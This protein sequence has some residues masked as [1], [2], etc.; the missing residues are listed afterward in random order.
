[1]EKI[2]SESTPGDGQRA[3]DLDTVTGRESGRSPVPLEPQ[4]FAQAKDGRRPGRPAWRVEQQ[5]HVERRGPA[6]CLVL[7]VGGERSFDSDDRVCK[8]PEWRAE[9]PSLVEAC[10]TRPEEPEREAKPAE[11]DEPATNSMPIPPD[12]GDERDQAD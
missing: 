5:T 12:G 2:G 11:A 7:R 1:M 8:S 3:G 4:S 9:D 10:P 6:Q